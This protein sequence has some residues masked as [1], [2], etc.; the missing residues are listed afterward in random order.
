MLVARSP[1]RIGLIGGGSDV[2]EFFR[3]RPS[4]GA[5]LGCTIGLSVFVAVLDLSDVSPER[6]RFTYR[7]TESVQAASDLEHPVV[8]A[9]LQDRKLDRRINIATMAD[10][11]GGTGLGS[12]SAFTVALL[13][14]IDA[15]EGYQRTPEE[16]AADAVR[17]ERE[18]LAEAGGWQD[19]FQSAMGGFRLYDFGADGVAAAPQLSDELLRGFEGWFLLVSTGHPRS[20]HQ[21][22]VQLSSRLLTQTNGAKSGVTGALEKMTLLAR[23]TYRQLVLAEPGEPA[24]RLLASALNEGWNLKME[25]GVVAEGISEALEKAKRAGALSGKLCGAGGGGFLFLVA[26]PERHSAIG[27]ALTGHTVRTVSLVTRG[28]SVTRI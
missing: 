24:A 10:V 14:A 9:V 28:V 5:V 20:S 13:A 4:G 26:P 2:P 3:K 21:Q 16:L 6:I 1:L 18:L 23:E 27:D 7:R 15:W 22:Q 25:T 8:R 12:S 11:P 19:Q 17:V